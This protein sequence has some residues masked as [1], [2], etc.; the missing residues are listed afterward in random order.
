MRKNSL[1]IAIL[2]IIL[3]GILVL[4]NLTYQEF[5]HGDVCPKFSIIPACYI[6]FV[7][8]LLLLTFQIFKKAT[9]LFIILAGFALTLTTF[10]SLGDLLHKIQCPISEIGIPTCFVGFFMFLLLI[11]L[12]FIQV[13]S[14]N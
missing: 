5:I 10:A 8:L 3:F 6:G 7:Y 2:T 13:K 11:I 14:D 9:I 1:N 4:G 12:K